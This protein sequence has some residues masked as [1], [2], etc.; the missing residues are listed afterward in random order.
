[1]EF[2][3]SS[4]SPDKQRQSCVVVGVFEQRRPTAA[5]A[6]LDQAAGGYLTDILG[7]VTDKVLRGARWPLL[8]AR[9]LA[10]A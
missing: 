6:A 9:P 8:L 3:T 7:T 2:S 4:G 10:A 5:A 1:M